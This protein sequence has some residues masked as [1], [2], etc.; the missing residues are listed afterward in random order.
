LQ[1]Q[2]QIKNSQVFYISN[3]FGSA[4]Q[5]SSY[6]NYIGRLDQGSTSVLDL[7]NIKNKDIKNVVESKQL[8]NAEE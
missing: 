5:A 8:Q 7:T 3:Q 1:T 4:P 6:Q 2:A